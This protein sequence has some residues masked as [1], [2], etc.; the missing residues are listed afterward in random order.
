MRRL[1]ALAEPLAIGRA[2]GVD[3]KLLFEVMAKG[4]ADS[5]AVRNQ[6]MKALLPGAFPEEA[7]PTDYALKDIGLALELARQGGVAASGAEL[8][9]DLLAETSR[10]GYGR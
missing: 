5:F 9:R 7:F 1:R 2:A 3:G 8:T 10:A 4:S 6:G